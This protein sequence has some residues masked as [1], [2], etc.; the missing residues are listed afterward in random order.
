MKSYKA[1]YILCILWKI[2]TYFKNNFHQYCYK[3]VNTV[4]HELCLNK[5]YVRN[6]L[7]IKDE[8][9]ALIKAGIYLIV[10]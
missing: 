6:K 2:R 7:V 9:T 4:K 1:F 10:W 5:T 3:N 8:Y